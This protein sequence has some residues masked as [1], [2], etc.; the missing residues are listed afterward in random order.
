MSEH[1]GIDEKCGVTLHD[2]FVPTT[3]TSWK[4][5]LIHV[6]DFLEATPLTIVDVDEIKVAWSHSQHTLN[7]FVDNPLVAVKDINCMLTQQ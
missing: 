5:I 6:Q 7:I 4:E 2:I 3:I 1:K